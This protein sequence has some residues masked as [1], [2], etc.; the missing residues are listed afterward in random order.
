MRVK[1]TIDM[2]KNQLQSIIEIDESSVNQQPN[3]V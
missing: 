2:E 1:I 3:R